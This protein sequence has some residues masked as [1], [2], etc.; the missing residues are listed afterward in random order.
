MNTLTLLDSFE[1]F[2]RFDTPHF[3]VKLHE[4]EVAALRPYVTELLEKAYNTL[5]EKYDFKPEGP[6]TFEMYP[7][8]ADFAVRT[9][10]LP[11]I[12]S[13]GSLLWKAFRDGFAVG[14]ASRTRSIGAARC[15]MNSRTSSRCR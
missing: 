13:P 9:L 7:D 14:A 5:S 11:G 2:E 10:G 1:H 15:G 8:H 3:K 12:R 4:K 6:I